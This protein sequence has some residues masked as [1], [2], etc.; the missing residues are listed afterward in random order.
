MVLGKVIN[1]S[2]QPIHIWS[3]ATYMDGNYR[4][5]SSLVCFLIIKCVIPT[6]EA[7]HHLL[8]DGGLEFLPIIRRLVTVKEFLETGPQAF[9]IYYE[10]YVGWLFLELP[11]HKNKTERY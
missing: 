1:W 10:N 6:C 3:S 11:D 9:E 7:R 5:V 4:R 2:A 8:L